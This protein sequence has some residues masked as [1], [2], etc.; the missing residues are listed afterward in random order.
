MKKVLLGLGILSTLAM[1]ADLS[2]EV[3]IESKVTVRESVGYAITAKN[4]VLDHGVIDA[5][6][7]TTA[8]GDLKIG[9]VVGTALGEIGIE[10]DLDP[11]TAGS[12][13]KLELKSSSNALESKDN[14]GTRLH[15]ELSM[16]VSGVH[17][18]GG[19]T[20][21]TLSGTAKTTGVIDY[22][23]GATANNQPVE[24]ALKSV[25]AN[26]NGASGDYSNTSTLVVTIPTA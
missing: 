2:T 1:A 15:Q 8:T 4:I 3:L 17:T 6:Q 23:V 5:G 21:S 7:V 9:R 13:V 12:V 26:T 22:T 25:I 19:T 14:N 24:V 11:L 18:I 16:T 10:S 20:T